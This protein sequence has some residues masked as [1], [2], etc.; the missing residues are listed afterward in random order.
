MRPDPCRA[1]ERPG[2]GKQKPI[3]VCPPDISLSFT[4]KA[5]RELLLCLF[6]LG[7]Y[8]LSLCFALDI[9][10]GT[11]IIITAS[12]AG[13]VRQSR[14]VALFA[15][16]QLLFLQRQVAAADALTGRGSF[17][18]GYGHLFKV[19]VFCILL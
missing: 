4:G 17:S 12:W 16:H 2:R 6:L 13:T 14:L 1:L 15:F 11:A 9:E 3:S 19:S 18:L 5:E 7:F 10:D 8:S